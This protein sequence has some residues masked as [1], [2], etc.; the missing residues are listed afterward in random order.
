MCIKDVLYWSDK[1]AKANE[2]RVEYNISF[3][4]S[5][6]FF[7]LPCSYTRCSRSHFFL[8]RSCGLC[9]AM[10]APNEL[11]CITAESVFGNLWMTGSDAR[12][13]RTNGE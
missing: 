2:I 8:Y 6:L 11:S 3:S 10:V 9:A 13:A 7:A 12:L 1:N 4:V 5:L